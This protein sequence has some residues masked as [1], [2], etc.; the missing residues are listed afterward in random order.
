MLFHSSQ[1][2]LLDE[3]QVQS[4]YTITSTTVVFDDDECAMLFI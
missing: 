4:M 1:F 2:V 3:L